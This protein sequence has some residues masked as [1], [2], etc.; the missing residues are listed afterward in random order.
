M[1]NYAARSVGEK[2]PL[3]SQAFIHRFTPQGVQNVK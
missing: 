3:K 1:T 2:Q